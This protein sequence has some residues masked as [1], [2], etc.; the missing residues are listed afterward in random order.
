MLTLAIDLG[1]TNCKVGLFNELEQIAIAKRATPY[2]SDRHFGKVIDP[3]ALQEMIFQM[4]DQIAEKK[5]A[6]RAIVL[7][8]MAETGLLVD[9]K[10]GH[11]LTPLLPWLND[12]A[13][14]FPLSKD[15]VAARFFKTGLR[16]GLKTS[17]AKLLYLQTHFPE[18]LERGIWLSV[19]DYL[20]YVLTGEKKAEKTLAQ[21]TYLFEL[22]TEAFMSPWA[23]RLLPDIVESGSV[24]GR[25]SA[26]YGSRW[27]WSRHTEVAVAGHDHVIASLI[28]RSERQIFNSIGTA[29][30]ILGQ[31][32]K[33][34]LVERDLASGLTF[35]VDVRPGQLY[36]MANIQAS[37]AATEWV[38]HLFGWDYPALLGCLREVPETPSGLLFLPYLSGVGTPL[39]DA[40]K[41]GSLQGIGLATTREQVV[42]AVFEGIACHF[43]LLCKQ[44]PCADKILAV[45]GGAQNPYWMQ[46]KADLTGSP[47]EIP[48]VDEPAIL[49][50]VKCYLKNDT[51]TEKIK[52]YY[53]P[54]EKRAR[55][56]ENCLEQVERQIEEWRNEQ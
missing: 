1:T 36:W 49:G 53:E 40:S 38:R 34:P 25:V 8:G 41:R 23:G 51:P 12:Q 21:R 45:G 3:V 39:F 18:R 24:T 32:P 31:M 43:A 6:V 30:T 46:L 37:G 54:D 44:L 28:S 11:P 48:D 17:Y 14:E 26:R 7:T 4:V 2:L 50:A 56:Y 19:E 35:G 22:E 29:E 5:A 52:Q 20:A 33:R 10:T 15:D 55:L 42:Q 47:V 13:A 16:G 27:R 9:R